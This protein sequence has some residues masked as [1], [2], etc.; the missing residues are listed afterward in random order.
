MRIE[1]CTCT[2]NVLVCVLVFYVHATINYRYT[3][4]CGWMLLAFCLFPTGDTHATIKDGGA[5]YV[6]TCL[7]CLPYVWQRNCTVY[8]QQHQHQFSRLSFT[9]IDW[10]V[11][12]DL[13]SLWYLGLGCTLFHV[14]QPCWWEVLSLQGTLALSDALLRN[15]WVHWYGQPYRYTILPVKHTGKTG[16]P[17]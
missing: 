10:I 16:I 12:T 3:N 8:M 11:S 14:C 15:N 2:K 5:L 1:L 13:I 17:A 6:V 9:Y 7:R 4:W